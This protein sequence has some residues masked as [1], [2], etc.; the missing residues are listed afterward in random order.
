M[1]V[2]VTT[3]GQ[4]GERAVE[5]AKTKVAALER[6]V[7]GALLGARVVLTQEENPR[8]EQP[9]RAEGEL[10]LAG[11]P[12]RA[13]TKAAS[14]DAAVDD[15]AELLKARMRDFVDRSIAIRRRAS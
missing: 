5:A 4:V 13:H 8:I 9:A 11:K 15:L 2:D 14:M 10:I 6:Y 1:N 7:D 12:I 3:R